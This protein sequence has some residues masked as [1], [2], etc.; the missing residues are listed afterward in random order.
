M[1]TNYCPPKLEIFN[2]K[3][4]NSLLTGSNKIPVDTADSGVDAESSLAREFFFDDEEED[5]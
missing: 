2:I 5:Y 4:T 1:K 3:I